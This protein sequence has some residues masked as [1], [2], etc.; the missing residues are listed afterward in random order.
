MRSRT[1]CNITGGQVHSWALGLLSDAKLIKDR[2][3]KCTVAIVLGITLR[4]AARCLSISAASPGPSQFPATM[5]S[6][7]LTAA[8]SCWYD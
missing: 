4:A 3:G 8:S 2:G 5:L 7:W 1:N 6:I